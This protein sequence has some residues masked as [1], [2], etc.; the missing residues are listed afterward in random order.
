MTTY[1][2]AAVPLMLALPNTWRSVSSIFPGVV[3]ILLELLL[4]GGRLVSQFI[5][6]LRYASGN[7]WSRDTPIS[8]KF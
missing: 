3:G 1:I 5:P 8:Q 4:F 2:P 7:S 6:F